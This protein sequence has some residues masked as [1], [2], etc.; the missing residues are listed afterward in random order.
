MASVSI[1]LIKD[2]RKKTGAGMGDCRKALLETD[3][4]VDAA[5]EHLRKSG[6][7]KQ[8]KRSER[9]TNEGKVSVVV[10]DGVGVATEVLCETD[11]V[12]KN[13]DFRA[14][15]D[16]LTATICGKYDGTGDILADVVAGEEEAIAAIVTNVRENL[17]IRRVVRWQPEDDAKLACYLHMGGK[18]GVMVEVAGEADQEYLDDL[19]QHIAAHNPQYLTPEDV[20]AEAVEKER[21]VYA[22]LPEMEG[23]PE[24]VVGKIIDGK[25]RKWYTD[26]CLVKQAWIWDPKTSVEKKNPKARIVR[27]LRWQVGEE[28]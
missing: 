8:A 12:A 19:C 15:C 27:F 6:L 7:L 9:A 26:I 1:D 24:Q 21:E 18:I 4:D 3:G 23:K 14:F 20:P 13:A 5:V 2:L 16:E 22:A 28:L 17:Q 25:V 11:F 10:T